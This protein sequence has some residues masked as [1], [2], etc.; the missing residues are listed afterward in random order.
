MQVYQNLKE[1]SFID[2]MH[3]EGRGWVLEAVGEPRVKF[4]LTGG[5]PC[6]DI[7]GPS[8]ADRLTFSDGETF[9]WTK[10]SAIRLHDPTA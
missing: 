8:W 7:Q 5:L 9:T 3:A 4:A 1:D 10:V 6:I 2:A